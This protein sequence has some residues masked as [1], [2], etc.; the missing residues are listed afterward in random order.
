MGMTSRNLIRFSML[1]NILL[2]KIK[3]YA[4]DTEGIS[5]SLAPS[6]LLP[7]SELVIVCD[8]TWSYADLY[9][10]FIP[11]DPSLEEK[12]IGNSRFSLKPEYQG[13]RYVWSTIGSTGIRVRIAQTRQSD[14][15]TYR[16]E[17]KRLR[18]E[19]IR[20]LNLD[21]PEPSTT[22][23]TTSD[24]SNL[25]A[26]LSDGSPVASEKS[27]FDLKSAPYLI[28][29]GG[30]LA[31]FVFAVIA[32]AVTLARRRQRVA[33]K[34]EKGSNE[35]SS[36]LK[37]DKARDQPPPLYEPLTA[38]EEPNESK[39]IANCAMLPDPPPIYAECGVAVENN[40]YAEC[41][42]GIEP[43]SQRSIHYRR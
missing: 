29:G 32:V 43:K 35:E 39:G 26:L 6:V 40:V 21:T 18:L 41:F 16:C 19:A 8:T 36:Y 38:Y 28:I 7:G 9:L 4:A 17:D 15:G 10:Y 23:A 20:V 22:I 14:A 5:L 27:F 3:I 33:D 30:V 42:P 34:E 11:L 25:D 12:Q 13:S 31:A 1:C 37:I 24:G 2:P